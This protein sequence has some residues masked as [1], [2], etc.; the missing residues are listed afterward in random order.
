MAAV[1][2]NGDSS[3]T[4]AICGNIVGALLGL[5]AIGPKWTGRL[6]MADMIMEFA[7]DLCDGC[8]MEEFGNYRDEIWLRLAAMGASQDGIAFSCGCAQSAVSDVLLAARARP[9]LEDS[10]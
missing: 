9:Y 3:S 5:K 1:N 8:Q 6:E 10:P 7:K 4:G 2:H